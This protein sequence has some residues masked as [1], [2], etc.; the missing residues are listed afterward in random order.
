MCHP[1]PPPPCDYDSHPSRVGL[2]KM[3]STRLSCLLSSQLAG[4]VFFLS[5]CFLCNFTWR[6]CSVCNFGWASVHTLV[7]CVRVFSAIKRLEKKNV[8]VDSGADVG[9]VDDC[10]FSARKLHCWLT[11]NKVCA[12]LCGGVRRWRDSFQLRVLKCGVKT[13]MICSDFPVI[14]GL[15]PLL[16]HRTK[17]I[18]PP[19]DSQTQA[20]S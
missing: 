18:G 9:A 13:Y 2:E 10:S 12:G 20:C 7:W 6:W 15:S 11:E 5:P 8:A 16:I 3:T 19:L 17:T 1:R 4:F 14:T